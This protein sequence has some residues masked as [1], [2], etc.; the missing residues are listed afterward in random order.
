[1]YFNFKANR[2]VK[3]DLNS[4]LNIGAKGTGLLKRNKAVDKIDVSVYYIN[5]AHSQ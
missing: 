1:M 4:A 5:G 2:Q 3:M